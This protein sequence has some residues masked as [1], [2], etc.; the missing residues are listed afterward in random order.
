MSRLK[1]YKS[2]CICIITVTFNQVGRKILKLSCTVLSLVA[3]IRSSDVVTNKITDVYH[4]SAV[5]KN[6]VSKYVKDIKNEDVKISTEKV[7]NNKN[8]KSRKIDSKTISTVKNLV[9]NN[10]KKLTQPKAQ[11]ITSA[12]N[13]K[14]SKKVSGNNYCN[15]T[16]YECVEVLTGDATFYTAKPGKR[17][18]NGEI[19]VAGVH[20][21]MHP[22]YKGSL[23]KITFSNGRTQLLKV[24]DTGGALI[25][26]SAVI[27][28]FRNTRGE[29][30]QE[31]RKKVKV[32][33]LRKKKNINK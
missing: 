10:S 11:K 29:C 13:T 9:K 30:L 21:A 12:S 17:M 8:K 15:L 23:A 24:G 26:G 2:R 32:E 18:S 4:A 5:E 3:T 22:K 25:N 27:D 20:C 16:D 1:N 6:I 14:I 7:E 19:P 33:I 28:I 31:G